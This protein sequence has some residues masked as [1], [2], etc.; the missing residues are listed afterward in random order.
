MYEFAASMGATCIDGNLADIDTA[1][2]GA[3][4]ECSVSQIV[5]ATQMET[6]LAECDNA[7]SPSS[8][9]NKPCWAIETDAL[10]CTSG[11]HLKLAIERAVVPPDAIIKAQCLAPN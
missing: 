8:S 9:T 6:L 10:T 1:T 11:T 3:Q 2:P 5:T 7:T 4:Y